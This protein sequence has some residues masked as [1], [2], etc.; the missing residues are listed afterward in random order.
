MMDLHIDQFRGINFG[1]TQAFAHLKKPGASVDRPARLLGRRGTC[2]CGKEPGMSATHRHH[3][4]PTHT[5]Q[6]EE[7]TP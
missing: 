7:T 5:S 1:I 3:Q 4:P 2:R 6:S